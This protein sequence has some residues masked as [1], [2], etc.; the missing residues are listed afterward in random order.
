M[1]QL[2]EGRGVFGIKVYEFF[3]WLLILAL[4]SPM[5]GIQIKGSEDKFIPGMRVEI[6]DAEWRID[7]V[8]VPTHGGMLLTCSGQSE[9]IRG[10]TALFLTDLETDPRVLLPETTELVDDLLFLAGRKGN[11]FGV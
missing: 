7:R 8:D 11:T 3:Y 1:L 5:V 9:L 2:S 6:R 4:E 10:I